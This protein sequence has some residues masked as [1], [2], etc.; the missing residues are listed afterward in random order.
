MSIIPNTKRRGAIYWFR[1]SCHLPDG[2]HLRPMVSLRTACPKTAR[3][4]AALLTAKFEEI[5][6][7]LFGSNKR[8]FALDADAAARIFKKE[9]NQALD[10]LEDERERATDYDYDYGGI[11]VFL[12]IHEAVYGYL[13]KTNC[14]DKSLSFA[15]WAQ[16]YANLDPG[17]EMLAQEEVSISPQSGTKI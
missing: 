11:G 6:M 16:L 13:A 4:R 5:Y 15:E 3:R 7:R 12:D 10:A 1:R 8:R 2:N 17:V 9:F 14:S